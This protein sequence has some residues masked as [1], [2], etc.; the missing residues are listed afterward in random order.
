[1]VVTQLRDLVQF[2]VVACTRSAANYNASHKILAWLANNCH[3]QQGSNSL[4]ET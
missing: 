1:M 4:I 2:V 3:K